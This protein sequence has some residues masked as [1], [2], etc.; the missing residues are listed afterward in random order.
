[1]QSNQRSSTSIDTALQEWP[2]HSGNWGRWPNDRGTLNLLT[3]EVVRRGV[4]AATLGRVFNLSRP[5][6]DHEPLRNDKCFEHQMLAAGAWDLEPERP[7]SLNASD[8]V[9]YRIHGMVNTH[10]DALSHVGYAGKGFNGVAFDEIAT[11][12]EGVKR[13]S[14]GNALGIV[15]R[16]Y[17]IDVARARGVPYLKPG[18]CVTPEDL[19]GEVDNLEAGD[20]VVIRLGGTLAGGI[21]P[22]GKENKHGI[23][24]GLHPECVEVLAKRDVSLIATDSSGDVFPAPYAHICRSATHTLSLVYYG[25]HL[26][27]NMDLE[28]LAT[29]CAAAT[30]NSFMFTVS[31]LHMTRATGSLVS[32][33]A[34]L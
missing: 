27:H 19:I 15:T 22:K 11:K 24:P 23:W 25:I 13:A 1:M 18:E 31:P 16:G 28:A 30:R 20:A 34:V 4:A 26:L 9:S 14:I 5:V 21:P 7:E 10:L 3:P 2:G 33:I 17:L 8:K 32:P 12:A 29:E 6:S